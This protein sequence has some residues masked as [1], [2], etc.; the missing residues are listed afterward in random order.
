VTIN[1]KQE[2]YLMRR[3]IITLIFSVFAVL[4]LVGISGADQAADMQDELAMRVSIIKR[5]HQKNAKNLVNAAQDEM[6]KKYFLAKSEK[7][8]QEIKKS[9]DQHSLA[10][11]ARFKVDEMCLID[12]NGQEISRI[13]FK[14]IAPDADLSSEE[15]S[16]PFY[17]P[18]F[19]A[20]LKKVHVE[21]PYMSA[22]SLRWVMAYAT[23]IVLDNGSKPAIYH[24]EMPLYALQKSAN[25][26]IEPNGKEYLLLVNKEGYIMSDS[27]NTFKLELNKADKEMTA[28]K[29]D[30]F[31]AL[32]D[33]EKTISDK[34]M[35]DPNGSINFKRDGQEYMAV[36][37]PVNY[38]AW[39]AVFISKKL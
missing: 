35:S 18:G 30:Y 32:K 33:T 26:N 8:K 11:Q 38:F 29:T 4:T 12:N 15:A 19:S 6:F 23:P 3:T 24:Y 16:A 31:P 7:E 17:K 36:F 14:E 37:G 13:V 1:S 10:V 5:F 34:V 25:R 27:R 9:I 20:K 22:D 21:K 39:K 28:P 2:E